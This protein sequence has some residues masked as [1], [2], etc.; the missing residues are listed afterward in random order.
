MVAKS[1]LI[2]V[3]ITLMAT[4][5]ASSQPRVIGNDIPVSTW[6]LNSTPDSVRFCVGYSM[7][8]SR[9]IFIKSDDTLTGFTSTLS[10]S[11]DASD[12]LTGVNYHAFAG[13]EINTGSF[14]E[15]TSSTHRAEDFVVLTLPRSVFHINVEIRDDL[16]KIT[17]VS[18]TINRKFTSPDSLG[19]ASVIFLDSMSND[20][21]Y[22]VMRARVAPF[23]RRVRFVL[24]TAMNAQN[25]LTVSLLNKDRRLVAK[26]SL[27]GLMSE[28]LE[29]VRMGNGFCFS[30]VC[31]TVHAILTGETD[32]DT[33]DEGSYY[34]QMSGNGETRTFPFHY[35][36]TDKPFTLRNFELAL[37]LL[38]YIVPDSINSE[39]ASGSSADRKEK[40]DAYWKSR[41]STPA[42]AY[43][44]L[45]AEYYERA[46]FANNEFRTLRTVNGA[47]TERGKA[48]ILFGKPESIVRQFRNDGTY[49]IWKYP[50]LKKSLVFKERNFGEFELYQTEQL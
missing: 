6:V 39:I 50:K 16:Q 20:R 49:E 1:A 37:S 23:P 8:F 25:R 48:Y 33:L 2:V 41:D 14:A 18:A 27:T 21:C 29:P 12:S 44:E 45:E 35:L 36:W 13:R 34:L 30:T 10:F 32:T 7:P 26:S 40:F 46:D 28:R 17:Y 9:L 11:V 38:R 3:L 24:V 31:D 42:T 4:G 47:L 19:I 15:S 5:T 43:N 22:P